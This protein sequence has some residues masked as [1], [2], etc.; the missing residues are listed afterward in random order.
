[1]DND[2]SILVIDDEVGPRESLRM[3][4]GENYD[5]FFAENGEQGLELL[6]KHPIDV[7]ILDLKMPGL[8]GIETLEL[9][10][11]GH[12]LSEVILL[13]GYG[14]LETAQEALR[15]GIFDYLTKPFDVND[16]RDVVKKAL[17][18][19][20]TQEAFRHEKDDFEK[21]INRMQTELTGFSR[22]AQIG[23]LSAGV[24]HQMK[25]PL[26]VIMGYTHMLSKLLKNNG[27]YNLSDESQKYLSIIETETIRCTEIAK[28][29][30]EYS[31]NTKG[32][33]KKTSVREILQCV[34]TMI[35]PQCS[36]NKIYVG[37]ETPKKDPCVSVIRNDIHEILLNL[38]FNSIYAMGPQCKLR[39]RCCEFDRGQPLSD[40]TEKERQFLN[41]SKNGRFVALS[42]ADTGKGIPG[43]NFDKVFE[44]FFTTKKGDRGTGLGLNICREKIEKN[45]GHIDVVRSDSEG[46]VMRLLLPSV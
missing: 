4:F 22:L 41:A 10:K 20:R 36:I 24:V 32:E 2:A 33:F 8:S 5:C 45:R 11:A 25:N 39:I 38:I 40:C 46:T 12:P 23:Q 3:V 7:V 31:R 34:E 13:T 9:I 44:A 14:S 43:E 17:E 16:L 19:K 35:L 37:I 1:M 29:L 42:V 6:D 21:M 18:R 15:L 28:R 27:K 30:L 26:T